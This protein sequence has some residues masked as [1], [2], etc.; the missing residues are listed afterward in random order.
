MGLFVAVITA[1]VAVLPSLI[2]PSHAAC[3]PCPLLWREHQHHCYRYFN[4][5]LPCDQ[6]KD[7]CRRQHAKRYTGDLAA[8]DSL[9]EML[10]LMDY[11]GKVINESSHTNIQEYVRLFK[12]DKPYGK[13][14]Y[15]SFTSCFFYYFI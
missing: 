10:S 9:D 3:S 4:S 2:G 1:I 15:L 13:A 8:V 11:L 5:P 7:Y 14:E 12:V 6:A